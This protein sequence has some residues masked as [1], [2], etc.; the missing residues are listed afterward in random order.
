MALQDVEN[1]EIFTRMKKATTPKIHRTLVKIVSPAV[2]EP[3]D[4]ASV[5]KFTS[6][7][8]K[9][10]NKRDNDSHLGTPANSRPSSRASNVRRLGSTPSNSKLQLTPSLILNVSDE[11]TKFSG[12][13]KLYSESLMQ[14]EKS[15]ELKNTLFECKYC[16][17]FILGDFLEM[18]EEKC[19][20][21][22]L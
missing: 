4:P 6:Q 18:H 7:F 3:H 20:T 12:I 22:S 2:K 1:F 19:G 14:R 15:A 5:S 9:L 21:E 10:I 17:R 16:G 8:K 13:G 11:S